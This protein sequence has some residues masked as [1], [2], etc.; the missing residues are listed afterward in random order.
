MNH[1]EL[2]SRMTLEEK[3]SLTSGKDFWQTVDIPYFSIPSL[4]CAD[5][6]SGLRRQRAAADHLGL[7]PSYPA[8][9]F[10]SSGTTANSWDPALMERVGAALGREAA[11]LDVNIFLAPGLNI[12]RNPKCGRNFEYFSEDPY[13]AGK[14]AAAYVRGVQSQG[15]SACPKHFAVNNR[16]AKRMVSD[17]VLDERTLREIYL[18]GFEIVVREAAP[19]ALMSSYNRVNG[20]YANENMHL[21]RDILRGEWGYDGIVVTDWGGENDR[22]EGLKAGNELEMPGTG[23]ETS[24]EIVRAVKEGRLD[25]SVLD[26]AIER[27]LTAVDA[28]RDGGADSFD[29]VAHHALAQEM[30]EASAVLLKNDGTLPLG[31]QRVALIGDF[32]KT[33]RYQG[34][35]S[36]NVN[37]TKVENALEIAGEYFDIVGYEPGFKRFGKRSEKLAARAAALAERA[38]VVLLYLGLDETSEA[39]GADRE[40]IRLPQNQLDLLDRLAAVGK[41]IVVVL[42]CGSAVEFGWTEKVNAVLH[43][44]LSGQAG[45][46]AL[47]RILSGAAN[48]CGKLTESCPFRYE[49]GAS[50]AYFDRADTRVEY[51]EGLFVGYRYY[52][53]AQVPV[54]YPFGFGL[55][56]TQFAYSDIAVSESEVSFTL[57]NTG[58]RDGAEIVQLYVAKPDSAVIRPVRELKGFEKVFLCAGEK[59][60]VTLRFDDKTFRFFDVDTAAWQREAGEYVIEI[61]ASSE[62]I[63]LSAPLTLSGITPR[64]RREDLPSYYRAAVADVDDGEFSRLLGCALEKQ[65][66]PVRREL[67]YTD[68]I[69]DLRWAK[70]GFARFLYHLLSGFYKCCCFFGNRDLAMTLVMGVFNQPFRGVYRMTGGMITKDMMDGVMQVVNGHFWRGWHHFFRAMRQKRRAAAQKRSAP[71]VE[72]K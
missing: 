34:A 26:E 44:G 46:R 52:A 63:R 19:R 43:A 54:C 57:Q 58:D 36:S 61:G 69:G 5:G 28:L 32:A 62:D 13:L 71:R 16:E 41:P 64:D 20:V 50:S 1:S 59:T 8:T 10:P 30:A 15:V 53:T 9:C 3:A 56:Y 65:A 55:S 48:P 35:G 27:L 39:E 31:K 24:A 18:T 14:M 6:P 12:K 45:A 21:M 42:S 29:E 2:I 51:R 67:G 33:S 47:L 70:G 40:H 17:S 25:E 60:R 23:G 7:N 49:D 37:P 11:A 72:E 38:D 66:V 68:T 22:V 4:Y